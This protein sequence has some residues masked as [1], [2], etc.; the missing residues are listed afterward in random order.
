MA[1]ANICQLGPLAVTDYRSSLPVLPRSGAVE[2]PLM[3]AYSPGC[4]EQIK[5]PGAASSM[6]R[7]VLGELS[8]AT[9]EVVA[10]A[11][12]S[13]PAKYALRRHFSGGHNERKERVAEK[14]RST[15]L[16]P[17]IC[18]KTDMEASTEN[19]WKMRGKGL[20]VFPS[21]HL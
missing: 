15:L 5:Y 21:Y 16:F 7:A 13:T 3:V 9:V 12:G 17:E 4:V 6:A 2:V 18:S 14:E 1:L 19:I 10:A 11:I 20:L 8:C